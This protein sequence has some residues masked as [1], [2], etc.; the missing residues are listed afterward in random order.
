MENARLLNEL[1]QRTDDLTEALEQQTA[2]SE[3]LQGHLA[4]RPA[5]WSRCSR[6]CWRMRRASARPSS[7]YCIVT[8]TARFIPRR[9]FDVPPAFVEFHPTDRGPF[10]PP[11]R[12][13]RS[14]AYRSGQEQV[15]HSARPGGRTNPGPA[16]QVRRRA[17]AYR[18]ADA[19]GKRAGR[20]HSSSTARRY[21]RSPTSRSSWCKNFA[22][23]AV[24]AIENTR[25]LNELRESLQQQTATSEVLKVIS[26]SP[27]EL[28]PVFD[29]ML[30]NAARI[31]GAK[32]GMLMRYDAGNVECALDGGQLQAAVLTGC[33]AWRSSYCVGLR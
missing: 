20:R 8:T 29:A 12:G 18:R 27:G 13:R 16:A 21:G 23:Q 4:V 25:L 5:S 22:A 17:I 31:C 33:R 30:A 10:L 24:I 9:S 19:Q 3:V 11:P 28:E 15:V 1:R 32:F 2:T 26:S 7:A 14:I 6:P